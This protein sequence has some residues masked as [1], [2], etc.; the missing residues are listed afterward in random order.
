MNCNDSDCGLRSVLVLRGVILVSGFDAVV[1]VAEA[2]PVALIPEQHAVSPV[3]LDV[4]NIGRLDIASLLHTLHTQRMCLKVTLAGSVPSNAVA[5]A[6]CGACVLRVEGTV[7][8]T[9]FGAVRYE[10]RTAGMTAR[11]V[12]SL[13]HWLH[14]HER[15]VQEPLLYSVSGGCFVGIVS[16]VF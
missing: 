11:C 4:I 2:L 10:R 6:A 15:L 1:T 5:S 13:G 9:V 14:L 12:W 8:V 3:R 7:L 16:K